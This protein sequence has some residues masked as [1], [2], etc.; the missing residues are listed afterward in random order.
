MPALCRL[1]SKLRGGQDCSCDTSQTPAEGSFNW[2]MFLSFDDGIEWVLC[3][4]RDDAA[5]RSDGIDLLLL[6]SE[7]A[8]LM[9]IRANTTVP[10]PEVFAYR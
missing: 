9:Y 6:A 8:T 4:P 5:F 2:A 7:A 10:V 3:S 1:A